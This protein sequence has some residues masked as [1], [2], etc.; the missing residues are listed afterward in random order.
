MELGLLILSI[1]PKH[2]LR[3]QP[4]S[5]NAQPA[6]LSCRLQTSTILLSLSSLASQARVG[7]GPEQSKRTAASNCS[8]ALQFEF[9]KLYLRNVSR[10]LRDLKKHRPCFPHQ[11]FGTSLQSPVP[12]SSVKKH[13]CHVGSYKAQ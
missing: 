13:L 12:F 9:K 3:E 2:C 1:H 5:M 7:A 11:V 6:A 8:A 10:H 4:C